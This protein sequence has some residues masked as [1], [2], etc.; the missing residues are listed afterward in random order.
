MTRGGQQ[1]RVL[2]S[3]VND[4]RLHKLAR[5]VNVSDARRFPNIARAIAERNALPPETRAELDKEW[6]G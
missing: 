6:E 3:A 5:P 4:L 1:Y 2:A